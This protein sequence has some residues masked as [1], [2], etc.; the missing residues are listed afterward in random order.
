MIK[1]RNPTVERN[2]V[3]LSDHRVL[4]VAQNL[5]SRGSGS[6]SMVYFPMAKMLIH[7]P[8]LHALRLNL[9]C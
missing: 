8:N 2:P 5:D 9:V 1:R 3:I 6:A 7:S 4:R